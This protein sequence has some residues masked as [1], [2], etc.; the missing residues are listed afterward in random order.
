MDC[1][2]TK[3]TLHEHLRGTETDAESTRH[4]A[5]TT[6]HHTHRAPRKQAIRKAPIN[7]KDES[8]SK[9]VR[10]G[11]PRKQ[12]EESVLSN[13]HL[14]TSEKGK[15]S[16]VQGRS[17][18]KDNKRLRSQASQLSNHERHR[19]RADDAEEKRRAR[20]NTEVRVTLRQGPTELQGVIDYTS[21]PLNDRTNPDA[22]TTSEGARDLALQNHFVPE[23]RTQPKRRKRKETEPETAVEKL[24]KRQRIAP[25]LPVDEE[26]PQNSVMLSKELS[27]SVSESPSVEHPIWQDSKASVNVEYENRPE[28]T[29]TA[30]RTLS[31]PKRKVQRK[32]RGRPPKAK[33]YTKVPQV[34]STKD[35][36]NNSRDETT[37]PE[38]SI[39]HQTTLTLPKETGLSLGPIHQRPQ[40]TNAKILI[41]EKE[42]PCEGVLVEN[43]RRGR[44]RMEKGLVS[45]PN[46]DPNSSQKKAGGKRNSKIIPIASHNSTEDSACPKALTT[47]ATHARSSQNLSTFHLEDQDSAVEAGGSKSLA[48]RED[49]KV[50]VAAESLPGCTRACENTKP[51]K[52]RPPTAA[53]YRFRRERI[54]DQDKNPRRSACSTSTFRR[55]LA[56]GDRCTNVP[57]PGQPNEERPKKSTRRL[58]LTNFLSDRD[59]DDSTLA[60]KYPEPKIPASLLGGKDSRLRFRL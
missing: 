54:T 10:R 55:R 47:K 22:V 34:S 40:P 52:A 32:P 44:P 58:A 9:Q 4:V 19:S 42:D 31:S 15:P 20:Q 28:L 50:R 1:S 37:I 53:P 59:R 6:G 16:T 3:E 8:R 11:R 27:P 17:K 48:E 56:L 14:E 25:A 39:G 7:V 21:K 38:Q 60:I 29:H 46:E 45:Q 2:V 41:P 12:A 5:G 18:S 26:E 36:V 51:S 23:P 49:V 13:S 43:K 24:H 33:H 30:T 35:T 57:S